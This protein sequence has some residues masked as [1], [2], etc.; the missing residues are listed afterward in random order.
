MWLPPKTSGKMSILPPTP[1]TYC[2]P[3]QPLR[4]LG[5]V[6][7]VDISKAVSNVCPMK[8]IPQIKDVGGGIVT[9]EVL[10]DQTDSRGSGHHCGWILLQERQG[11]VVF[12][13]SGP[14]LSFSSVIMEGEA[15]CWGTT[16]GSASVP[17]QA[18]ET[19]F[20]LGK[21]LMCT[22]R[23]SGIF[24]RQE[25]SEGRCWYRLWRW[26]ESSRHS[27]DIW[28]CWE[29]L[30]TNPACWS[31]L[32]NVRVRP[33]PPSHLFPTL[34]LASLHFVLGGVT[35][36]PCRAGVSLVSSDACPAPALY[37]LQRWQEHHL[38]P[39]A[40]ALTQLTCSPSQLHWLT[41]HSSIRTRTP[42]E[43]PASG[44]AH[45]GL[46][47]GTRHS[48]VSPVALPDSSPLPFFRELLGSRASVPLLLPRLGAYCALW[49]AFTRFLTPG[50]AKNGS[51]TP[52]VQGTAWKGGGNCA[53]FWMFKRRAS[54][55]CSTNTYW[56]KATL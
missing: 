14:R 23:S 17:P 54:C 52:L 19:G 46:P 11:N 31:G 9:S 21:S 25:G 41:C 39:T 22:A 34:S 32:E 49:R 33:A 44:V 10:L 38:A 24:P 15:R 16:K 51:A 36:L 45:G 37:T 7:Q 28:G 6:G 3:E 30:K 53:T 12:V 56:I 27:G 55:K 48:P 29:P 35:T 42:A 26:R 5:K 2:L 47:A 8:N 1:N 18:P 50:Q 13:L 4:S 43:L 40:L 20:P